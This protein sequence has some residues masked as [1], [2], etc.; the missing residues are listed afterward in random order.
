MGPVL[1][2]SWIEGEPWRGPDAVSMYVSPCRCTLPCDVERSSG[3]F[4]LVTEGLEQRPWHGGSVI[5]PL[6]SH[7][8]QGRFCQ[9]LF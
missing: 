1:G 7:S 8:P 5:A 2:S 6:P 4:Y 9:L 3:L